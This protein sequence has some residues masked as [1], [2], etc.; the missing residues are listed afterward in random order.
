MLPSIQRISCVNIKFDWFGNIFVS[1]TIS[2]MQFINMTKYIGYI[3]DR[4]IVNT[5]AHIILLKSLSKVIF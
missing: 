1:S 5:T 4:Y 2:Q 3:S